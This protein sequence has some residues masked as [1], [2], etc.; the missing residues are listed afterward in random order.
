[1]RRVAVLSVTLALVATAVSAVAAGLAPVLPR[2]AAG[3]QCLAEPAIMRREHMRMI[4]HVQDA[5]GHI[6][7]AKHSLKRCI[8]CHA[9][10]TSSSVARDP[11]DFCVACH[12]YAA[13]KIECF[14]CH[15]GR[16]KARESSAT[17]AAAPTAAQGHTP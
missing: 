16:A 10:T 2:A 15:N 4:E 6:R 17:P 1:M 12:S 13:V 7:G 11:G 5:D 14:D 9:S 8:E 3:T